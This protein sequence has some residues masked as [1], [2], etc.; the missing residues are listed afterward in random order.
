MSTNTEKVWARSQQGFREQLTR[1]V[2]SE[3]A[4]ESSCPPNLAVDLGIRDY[5]ELVPILEELLR[6]EKIE[7]VEGPDS[8]SGLTRDEVLKRS[9]FGIKS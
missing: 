4:R 9:F 7:I 6:T 3:L 8:E 2:L 5:S 1:R